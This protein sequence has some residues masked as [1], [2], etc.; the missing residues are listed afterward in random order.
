MS[1]SSF[2]WD[3]FFPKKFRSIEK[4]PILVLRHSV[5]VAVN[6]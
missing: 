5:A 1:V 6:L 2:F 4:M 3:R